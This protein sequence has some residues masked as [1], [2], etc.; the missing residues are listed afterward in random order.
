MAASQH[1][2]YACRHRLHRNF[3]DQLIGGRTRLDYREQG[4]HDGCSNKADCVGWK[5]I[6]YVSHGLGDFDP[7]VRA[8]CGRI[9]SAGPLFRASTIQRSRPQHQCGLRE[10]TDLTSL[11]PVR[12]RLTH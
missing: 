1:R 12:A 4:E 6:E 3:A 9:K 2:P 5:R 11:G 10:L 7:E 8:R